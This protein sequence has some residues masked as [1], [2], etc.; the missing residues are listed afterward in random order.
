MIEKQREKEFLFELERLYHKYFLTIDLIVH[1]EEGLG[2][3]LV[4]VNLKDTDQTT[5]FIEAAIDEL[6]IETLEDVK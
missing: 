5:E 6:R 1:P 3:F 4:E 2:L